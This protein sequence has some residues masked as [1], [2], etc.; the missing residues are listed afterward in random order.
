MHNSNTLII[1]R[2][3]PANWHEI[4]FKDFSKRLKSFK[5]GWRVFEDIPD[6]FGLRIKGRKATM[7]FV[8][9]EGG[10]W[11]VYFMTFEK[12]FF[13]SIVDNS[14]VKQLIEKFEELKLMDLCV[15]EER[16]Y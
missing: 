5:E 8:V 6:C 3:E 7:G 10:I 2:P 14:F 16:K 9:K 15:F 12:F 1:D 11:N 13:K 4:D